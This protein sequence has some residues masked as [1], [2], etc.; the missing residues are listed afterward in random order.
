[1]RLD[2][3]ISSSRVLTECRSYSHPLGSTRVK[4]AM[5]SRYSFNECG[6]GESERKTAVRARTELVRAKKR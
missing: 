4:S 5:A 3:V 6:E 1:M 2:M